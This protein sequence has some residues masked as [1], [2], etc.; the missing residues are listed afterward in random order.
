MLCSMTIVQHDEI[1]PHQ[2]ETKLNESFPDAQFHIKGYQ[3]PAFRKDRN[4]NSG[5]KIVYV[6]EWLI[7]K[8]ILEYE[9]TICIEIT[10]SKRKCLT[11]HHITTTKQYFFMDLNKSLCNIARKYESI[12]VIGDLNIIF[13]NLKKRDI[14]NHLSDLCD[15]FSLSNLVN[16]ITCVKSQNG[17]S[18]DMMF[19]NRPRSFHNTSLIKSGLS[20]CER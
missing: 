10:I 17:T 4:I 3:Y 6:K 14:Q 20:D 9:R 12:L 13:D 5:G 1:R 2:L 11:G 15:T 18:I 16:G 19:T 8:R 7:A